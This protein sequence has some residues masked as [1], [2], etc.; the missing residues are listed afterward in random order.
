MQE[1][2]W[3]LYRN[4]IDDDG[5]IQKRL[6]GRFLLYGEFFSV[7]EDHDNLLEKLVPDGQVT[8]K[9]LARFKNMEQS[10]YW[11]LVLEKDVQEGKHPDLLPPG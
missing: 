9:V 10:P 5:G 3:R 8:A 7:L 4:Y 6:I 2:I 11:D 1:G